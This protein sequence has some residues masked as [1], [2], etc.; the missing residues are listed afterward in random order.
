MVR[1][2]MHAALRSLGFR[3]KEARAARPACDLGPDASLEQRVR[4]ALQHLAPPA[5]RRAPAA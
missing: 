1:G 3:D 4:A 5:T 2:S